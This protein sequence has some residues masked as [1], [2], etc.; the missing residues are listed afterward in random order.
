M[1]YNFAGAVGGP[2][3]ETI[4]G[5]DRFRYWFQKGP[6]ANS[7]GIFLSCVLALSSLRLYVTN[8]H[9]QGGP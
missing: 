9:F 6:D 7:G 2:C 4:L 1:R 8:Y 3:N 5:E